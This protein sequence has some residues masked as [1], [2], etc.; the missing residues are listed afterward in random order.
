MLF[1]I[2]IVAI[3]FIV[4]Y[5][6]LNLEISGSIKFGLAVAEMLIVSQILVKKY[7]LSSELGMILLKSTKGLEYIEK[8]A[9]KDKLFSFIADFGTTISY[10][11]LGYLIMRKN[12]N[13][14]SGLIGIIL[15]I[16]L[17]IF[18]APVS[19]NVLVTMIKGVSVDKS[20]AAIGSNPTEALIFSSIILFGGG[21]FLLMLYGIA[22]YGINVLL[23]VIKTLFYGSDALSKTTAGGALLLPGI[24]LPFLEGVLALAVAIIVHEA[25][26]AILARIAKVKIHSSGLV[27]FGIIPMGAFVEPDEK[28][29]RSTVADKQTRIIVAGPTANFIT[30][31]V[32]FLLFM[33]FIYVTS[34]AKEEGIMILNGD[35]HGAVIHSINSV[36]I[37]PITRSINEN[38]ETI[39]KF[40]D[41]YNGTLTKGS[42]ELPKN[43]LITF[44][45]SKGIIEK[46]SDSEGK[47]GILIS[48]ITRDGINAVYSNGFLQFIYTFL[49]L[50]FALNFIV[51]SVNLLPVPV[52]D[53]SRLISINVE[54]QNIVKILTY[55]TVFFFALNFLPLLIK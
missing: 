7:N 31:I 27:L 40:G 51:G 26:H 43:S 21:I 22:T 42:F 47:T 28:M 49:A 54:N 1:L 16:V 19:A 10:G 5:G 48:I 29:L 52:F 11:L 6:I 4:F 38:G 44:E 53:G 30:S 20:A 41:Y 12:F 46:Q 55:A 17:S 45:T 24:N 32:F 35:D 39:Y 36:P 18:V 15:L 25:A 34:S 2:A 9:Q 50:T 23:A 13:L 3:A 8:L 14:K 37:T 33:S